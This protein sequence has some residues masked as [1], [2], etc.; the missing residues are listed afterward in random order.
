MPRKITF[1]GLL[2]AISLPAQAQVLES[3]SLALVALYDSTDGAN[4]TNTWDLNTPVDTWYGV[5]VSGGRVTELCLFQ[6]AQRVHPGRTGEP[7]Q[8]NSSLS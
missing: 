8:S 1:I 2:L 5:T 3:D 7:G 6:P 4:W